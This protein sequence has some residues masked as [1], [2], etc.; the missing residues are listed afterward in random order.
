MIDM[1]E[2]GDVR[3]WVVDRDDVRTFRFAHRAELERPGLY[4][5]AGPDDV[6]RQ[7]YVG[8]GVLFRRVRRQ[9][10][11]REF[12]ERVAV[13]SSRSERLNKAHSEWLEARLIELLTRSDQYELVNLARTKT[14]RPLPYLHA[15][16]LK[17]VRRF[18]AGVR[19]ALAR[20]DIIHV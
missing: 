1:I 19:R 11:R 13:I 7:V 16:D 6:R 5:L 9:T 3:M 14:N 15:D 10:K 18:L 20:A 8:E 17:I 4:V 2:S 12:W